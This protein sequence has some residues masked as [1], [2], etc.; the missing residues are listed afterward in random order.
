[1]LTP[2]VIDCEGIGARQDPYP[3]LGRA[4]S[5]RDLGA[6]GQPH[7]A[8][9]GYVDAFDRIEEAGAGCNDK[10]G[11]AGALLVDQ[12]RTGIVRTEPLPPSAPALAYSRPPAVISTAPGA[13][14]SMRPPGTESSAWLNATLPAASSSMLPGA[15]VG[16]L[17]CHP[18]TS[19]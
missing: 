5:G 12:Q 13:P 15:S 14:T 17:P 4:V 7:R 16:S 6:L 3:R 1:M 11:R 2:N 8:G 18:R 19:S 9:D 10:F